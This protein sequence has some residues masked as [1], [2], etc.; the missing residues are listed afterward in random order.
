MFA[1]HPSPWWPPL[2]VR[3]LL[4]PLSWQ[5]W[6]PWTLLH[7]HL[8]L[9]FTIQ[10]MATDVTCAKSRTK[11]HNNKTDLTFNAS[12]VD[13]LSMLIETTT[14]WNSKKKSKMKQNKTR[15]VCWSY[16][17]LFCHR[18][19]CAVSVICH[20]STWSASKKQWL[21]FSPRLLHGN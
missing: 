8:P 15:K 21:L 4:L 12:A 13:I 9:H 10:W 18:C 17:L 7:S 19:F 3:S 11:R 14:G 16:L 2:W 5:A 6:L 1:W 20:C